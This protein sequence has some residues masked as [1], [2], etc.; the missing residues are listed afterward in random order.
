MCSCEGD[1]YNLRTFRAVGLRTG[2]GVDG[3]IVEV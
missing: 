3:G 1:P 2:N